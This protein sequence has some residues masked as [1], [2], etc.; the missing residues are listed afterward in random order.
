MRRKFSPSLDLP[1]LFDS[2][3]DF[4]ERL[5]PG[6]EIIPPE[7]MADIARQHAHSPEIDELPPLEPS[8]HVFFMSFGSGSSGNCAYIGDRNCGFL[9]D[10]GIDAKKVMTTLHANGIRMENVKG[11]ILTHDHHDHI[12]QAYQILRGN[13]HMKLYCTLRTLNGI[14]RRHNVSRRI[15]DYHSPIYKE[16]TFKIG[17][18]EITPFEV[19]HDGAD[20]AGFFIS[21]P[22]GTTI[23]VATD[24]GCISP[25]VDHYMRQATSIVIESN[26]DL[27]MLRNGIYPEYLK[28]RIVAANGHLDNAVTARF[29]AEIITPQVRNIFLCHLSHDNNTPEIALDT[30]EE[31]IASR[32]DNPVLTPRILALP[33]YSATP[34]YRL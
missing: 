15:K 20:N 14:L 7:K 22:S 27:M 21:H 11:I 8:D 13:R 23:A 16:F 28:A 33:R 2:L 12:A 6:F 9:I 5:D 32:G 24:L 29:I 18:F 31:A 1:G 26:Y 25:R 30:I 34:L 4:N 19:M 10:A 17:A 3:D